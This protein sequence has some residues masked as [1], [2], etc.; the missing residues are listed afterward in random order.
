[1][2]G[3]EPVSA[4]THGIAAVAALG[5]MLWLLPRTL[6]DGGTWGVVVTYGLCM[7]LMF[8]ASAALHYYDGNPHIRRWLNK[9]DHITIYWMIAGSYTG[10]FFFLL[11]GPL[12]WAAIGTAWVL[13][14]GGTVGKLM[15]FRTNSP[16]STLV[17]IAIGLLVVPF[18]PQ[19]MAAAPPDVLRLLL[20]GGII[21]LTGTLVYTF[22]DPKVRPLF[23]PHEAWHLFVMA[24]SGAHFAAFTT[25]I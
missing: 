4:V 9:F 2:F 24:G 17:Y 12:R 13:A 10:F 18:G 8:A 6:G 14:L 15:Q 7:T 22:D 25:L 1:M 5:G 21:Y 20:A 16:R 11:E 23:G 19:V 3:K